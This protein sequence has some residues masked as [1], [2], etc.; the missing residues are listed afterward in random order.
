MDTTTSYWHEV[1]E[2]PSTTRHKTLIE[3]D[4]LSQKMVNE[5]ENTLR[6]DAETIKS[7]RERV[8][9]FEVELSKERKQVAKFLHQTGDATKRMK[10]TSLKLV[11]IQKKAKWDQHQNNGEHNRLTL[12]L[13][14]KLNAS[15]SEVLCLQSLLTKLLEILQSVAI[16]I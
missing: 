16:P 13:N 5:S 3:M 4:S 6:N 14:A 10:E 1:D 11:Q 2:N 12:E 8:I 15:K 9:K 7:L